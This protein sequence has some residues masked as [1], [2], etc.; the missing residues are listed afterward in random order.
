MVSGQAQIDGDGSITL[1]AP[2]SQSRADPVVGRNR[3][4]TAVGSVEAA[5]E[6]EVLALT[7]AWLDV[8]AIDPQRWR[9]QE[10][11]RLGVRRRLDPAQLDVG[12]KPRLAQQLAQARNQRLVARA[13]IEVQKLD[14]RRHAR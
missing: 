13:A 14:P 1:V 7:G 4:Q 3:R 5:L 11:L 12:G 2:A 8:D 9:T 10:P 6:S